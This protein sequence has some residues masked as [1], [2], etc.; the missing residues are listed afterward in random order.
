MT[1][2]LQ[3]RLARVKHRD[4][5]EDNWVETIFR[6]DDLGRVAR[7]GDGEANPKVVHYEYNNSGLVTKMTYPTNTPTEIEYSYDY[8][9]RRYEIKN[10]SSNRVYATNYQYNLEHQL[11]SRTLNPEINPYD[12][13]FTYDFQERLIDKDYKASSDSYFN[14]QLEYL[15]MSQLAVPQRENVWDRG[16]QRHK[17]MKTRK[18]SEEKIVPSRPSRSNP[19]LKANRVLAAFQL[20]EDFTTSLYVDDNKYCSASLE[21]DDSGTTFIALQFTKDSLPDT[22]FQFIYYQDFLFEGYKIQLLDFGD[23]FLRIDSDDRFIV[24]NENNASLFELEEKEEGFELNQ[25]LDP[26]KYWGLDDEERVIFVER[27]NAV[28]MYKDAPSQA[29][30]GYIFC[31]SAEQNPQPSREQEMTMIRGSRPNGE[32]TYYLVVK[33][34]QD[35]RTRF[36]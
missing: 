1:K 2:N 4:S 20:N 33:N 36:R 8:L 28:T 22:Q 12:E 25:L 3:G 13:I 21:E 35:P 7:V 10:K 16:Q 19:K 5:L 18:A 32:P 30:E 11:V 29:P 24:G 14:Q 17:R 6:Y 15:L 23:T 27:H 26:D 31:Q 34:T 9:G